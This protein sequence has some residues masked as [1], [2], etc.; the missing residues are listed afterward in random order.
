MV[1]FYTP[2]KKKLTSQKLTVTVTKLDAFGQGVANH[3]GKTIF[4]KSALP[5]ETVDIQLTEDKK[6]YAK[7]KVI[8]YHNYSQQRVKPKC[9]YYTKCGGCELQHISSELQ[10]QAKYEA[11]IKLL[12]KETGALLEDNP[13]DIVADQ[14]YH[15]RRR[16]RLAINLV[17]G[18]LFIGFRQPES[19]QII[20]IEH[21]P[22]LVEQLD[23]LLI[24]LQSCL[25]QI[26]QKKALGHI[27]LIAVDSGIILVLR[28][29]MPLT[30]Q[31]SRL[32][33][34]FAAV[35]HISLYFHGDNLCHAFGT[36]E[37]YYLINQLKLT[38]SP[39]DFIQVNSQINQKMIE[40]ALEWLDVSSN[41]KILDL[42]CGMGNFSLPIA[43]I[44]QSVTGIEGVAPL[45]EKAKL[46]AKLNQDKIQAKTQFF[47]CNLE[48]KQQFSLWNQTIYDKIL[49]DPAR[50][51][52]YNASAEIV[53]ISPSKLVYISCNPATLARD[54][55]L[56]I[57]EGYN[58]AKIAILDMFPQTKHIESMLMLT[59]SG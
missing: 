22:V 44:C 42:F 43:T 59:R 55:K 5:D 49:L 51:G 24:P 27:E 3:K 32:L 38:F 19:S 53:K 34:Q 1:N 18:E 28:H 25:R 20:N 11:L 14:P 7:A 46:N 26:K 2:P 48:D 31:D 57:E 17:K 40:K 54:C 50:A 35:H 39:L 21:C 47:T 9:Q 6:N 15:Y 16:A 30:E 10:Q 37:H 58:I 36:K 4:V 23:A 52:A 56:F 12:S 29:T 41:D 33:I 45:V 8:K 13:P